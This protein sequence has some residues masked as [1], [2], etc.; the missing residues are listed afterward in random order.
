MERY[1]MLV[2]RYGLESGVWGYR[3]HFAAAGVR[4]GKAFSTI[5]LIQSIFARVCSSLCTYS[6]RQNAVGGEVRQVLGGSLGRID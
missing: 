6:E 3:V 4:R 5:L 1:G 2:E